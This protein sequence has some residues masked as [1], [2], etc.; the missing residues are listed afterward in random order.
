MCFGHIQTL[1]HCII[2]ILCVSASYG[3]IETE[4]RCAQR[5]QSHCNNIGGNNLTITSLTAFVISIPKHKFWKC[6]ISF[7]KQ[8]LKCKYMLTCKYLQQFGTSSFFCKKIVSDS[9]CDHTAVLTL[10]SL[11]TP[12]LTVGVSYLVGTMQTALVSISS[13][14]LLHLSAVTWSLLKQKGFNL[15]QRAG[16][17]GK[18]SGSGGG[19]CHCTLRHYGIL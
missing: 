17:G 18:L 6:A 5:Q 12:L 15:S 8:C 13:T 10:S 14:L 9:Y 1:L 19:C 3:S 4:F 7:G 11:S 2:T 16:R